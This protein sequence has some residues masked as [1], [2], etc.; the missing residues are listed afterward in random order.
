VRFVLF[1]C[2]LKT[3][4]WAHAFNPST[5]EAEAGGSLEF[6][7]SLAYRASSRIASLGYSEKPCLKKQKQKIKN[8]LL[9]GFVN[10]IMDLLD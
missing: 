4:S 5:W 9:N 10:P 6:E 7:A 2:K 1:C 8:Y 3:A